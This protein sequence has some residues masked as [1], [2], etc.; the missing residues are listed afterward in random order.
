MEH[1]MSLGVRVLVPQHVSAVLPTLDPPTPIW[2][3]HVWESPG[4]AWRGL[5]PLLLDAP[6]SV[7]GRL[8]HLVFQKSEKWLRS[9]G[10]SGEGATLRGEKHDEKDE[11]P[12]FVS[13]RIPARNTPN[14]TIVL[15]PPPIVH[16]DYL[17]N[18]I[19]VRTEHSLIKRQTLTAW[20]STLGGGYFFCK[21]LQVS[22]LLARQQKVLALKIGNISMARQCQVNEAYNLIY[23]G[24]FGAAKRVLDELEQ[25]CEEGSLTLNQCSAARLFAKRL[26][27]VKKRG[28]K[29]YHPNEKG[30]KHVIDDYQRIRIVEG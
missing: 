8:V 6:P 19:V 18:S 1:S 5:A 13:R 7:C 2:I 9:S 30:E 29:S 14:G 20:W 23:A 21:R 16:P 24:K 17:F 3:L 15:H 28:L 22:L 11:I 12:N 10:S 25:A 27:H 26:K 4:V